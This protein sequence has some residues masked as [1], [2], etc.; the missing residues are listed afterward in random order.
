[1]VNILRGQMDKKTLGGGSKGFI[2]C[3]YNDLGYKQSSD[4]IDDLQFIVTEYMKLSSF[5]VGISDLIADK[6][7]SEQIINTVNEKKK[8]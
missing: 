1:M 8:K 6:N 7:T 4:F 3:I 5:S 2:Q